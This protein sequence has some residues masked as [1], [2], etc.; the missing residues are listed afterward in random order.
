MTDASGNENTCWLERAGRKVN[1]YCYAPANINVDWRRAAL[2]LPDETDTLQLQQLFGVATAEDNC[3]GVMVSEL[4]PVVDLECGVGTIIRRFRAVDAAGSQS[5]N[6]CQQLVTIS[7]VHNYEIR[8]PA[9]D[10]EAI[11]V[12]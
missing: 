1:P 8:F 5:L 7:G 4:P 3:S 11:C 9:D 12:A 10:A 6:L 2:R